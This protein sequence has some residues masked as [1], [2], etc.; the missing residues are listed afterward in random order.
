[1]PRFILL[2]SLF[3]PVVAYSQNSGYTNCAIAGYFQGMDEAF[4]LDLAT[5]VVSKKDQWKQAACKESY[6]EGRKAAEFYRKHRE[7][8]NEGDRL[9]AQQ[10]ALFRAKVRRFILEGIGM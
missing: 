8:K 6:E 4:Y 2:I 9:I 1:M 5:A 3:I 10:A 7:P